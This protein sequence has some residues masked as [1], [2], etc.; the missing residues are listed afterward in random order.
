M[1][2][3]VCCILILLF[4]GVLDVFVEFSWFPFGT[5]TVFCSI[6]LCPIL[7]YLFLLFFFLDCSKI[8]HLCL[9]CL[10]VSLGPKVS[11]SFVRC[12]PFQ[13]PQQQLLHKRK[14]VRSK[15]HLCFCFFFIIFVL[16]LGFDFGIFSVLMF[17]KVVFFTESYTAFSLISLVVV[18]GS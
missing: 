2:V 5:R 14:N 10:L 18:F 6:S 1:H 12:I 13:I 8:P 9:L 7:T 11:S 3:Y 17:Q 15:N 16:K 4:V